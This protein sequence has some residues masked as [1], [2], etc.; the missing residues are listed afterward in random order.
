VIQG[1]CELALH[2]QSRSTLTE[3]VPVPPAGPNADGV[4]E[5]VDSH[6]DEDA[7]EGATLVDVELPHPPMARTLANEISAMRSRQ[8]TRRQL[9]F[10]RTGSTNP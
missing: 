5:T 4:G 8:P 9:L 3:I 10:I 2:V 1:D 6:R 7:L